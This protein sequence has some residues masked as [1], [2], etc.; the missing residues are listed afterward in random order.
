MKIIITIRIM[1]L[2]ILST[3]DINK[4]YDINVALV[5]RHV[6]AAHHLHHPDEDCVGV[7]ALVADKW[8]Q[9]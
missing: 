4:T 9:H 6:L 7:G 8:G 5:L 1:I 3:N 2:V